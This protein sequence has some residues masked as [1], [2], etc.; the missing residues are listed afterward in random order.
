MGLGR[1]RRAQQAELFVP[2]DQL[3]RSQGHA[4]YV[5]LNQLLA[6]AGFNDRVEALSAPYYRPSGSPGRPSV[7]PGVYFR[8]LLVGY[9]EGI[10]S[11]RGIAWRCPDSLSLRAF[12][13]VPLTEDV[14]DHSSLTRIRDRLPMEVHEAAFQFVFALAKEQGLST[15]K[16]VAVDSTM[17]EANAAVRSIS[18]THSLRL[19]LARTCRTIPRRRQANV[20][21][22]AIA[23]RW[24]RWL[25]RH[26]TAA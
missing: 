20:V 5:Q 25:F 7:P 3:P 2:A 1:R 9:F 14:P 6:A 15:W 12:L 16:T 24:V 17:L 22:P 18:S 19:P 13:G 11:Q 21:A 10:A 26:A 8:M 4:F 23:N